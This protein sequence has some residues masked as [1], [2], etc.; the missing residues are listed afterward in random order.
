MVERFAA[1][2]GGLDE[3]AQ[4]LLEICLA[5]EVLHPPWSKT[6]VELNGLLLG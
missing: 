5:D 6:G 2:L 3:D 1:A 4:T